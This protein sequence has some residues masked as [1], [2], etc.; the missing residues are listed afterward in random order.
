MGKT[1]SNKKFEAGRKKYF[2]IGEKSK[3]VTSKGTN[4]RKARAEDMGKI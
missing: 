4:N 1:Y 2:R 3:P